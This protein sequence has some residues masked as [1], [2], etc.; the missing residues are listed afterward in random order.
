[1]RSITIGILLFVAG[2]GTAS[3]QPLAC[4]PVA[5]LTGRP[6]E[7]FHYHVQMYRPDSR[8]F[9]EVYGINQFSSQSACD[10]ARDSQQKRNMALIEFY[11]TKKNDTQYQPDRVG[12]CHCDNTIDKSSTN[13]LT[14]T[15]RLIQM[16][17]A[18]DI[19][20]RVRERL[21]DAQ[22]PSDSEI[23][24]TSTQQAGVTSLVGGPRLTS[25]PARVS[26][27]DVTRSA[28][29]LKSTRTAETSA[30]SVVSIDLPLV[31]IPGT[32]AG[33]AVPDFAL[34]GTSASGTPSAA[35]VVTPVEVKPAPVAPSTPPPASPA[36]APVSMAEPAA[37]STSTAPVP[38]APSPAPSSASEPPASSAEEAADAFV[39]YETQRIQLVLQASSAITDESTRSKV[40][41]A[42]MQRIQLLSN[43][44][45]LIQGS[46]ARSRLAAAA[47]GA[48]T[49]GERLAMIARVFGTDMQPHWAPKDAAD[50]VLAADAADADPEKVLRDPNNLYND[51]QK[52]RALYSLLAHSQPT[53]EQQLWLIT[54]VDSFL[55]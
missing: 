30:L 3:G 38:A 24:R 53:E 5:N 31:D 50:V 18:E 1:M 47:R 35:S 10:S 34:P 9:V 6:C 44:R 33:A 11:R 27:A 32:A 8:T 45:S 13:Y 46:G 4:P 43:L 49:E 29:D 25:M 26:V 55:Q 36:T 2:F 20:Q 7:T 23:L 48:Q 14:D 21:M 37:G 42:C 15:Q 12:A 19:R 41:E 39:S 28:E 17:T 40:L 54:V 16:R 52:K 51:Q 22:V